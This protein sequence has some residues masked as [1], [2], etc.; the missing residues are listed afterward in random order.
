MPKSSLIMALAKVMIAAAWAD[1]Q[2]SNDE[3]NSLKDLLFHLPGM[4][5]QDWAQLEIY[6]ASPVDAEERTRL[7]QEL[8]DAL[9][10]S[11]DKALA[12]S[13]LDDIVQADGA[14][15]EQERQVLKEIRAA[16]DEVNVNILSQ[17]GRLL[18][19]PVR[20]RTH[21]SEDAPNREDRLDD[22]MKNRIYYSLSRRLEVDAD[23]L[24]LPE[25][26]LRKL[27][28]AG[29]LMARIAYV[30]RDVT[31]GE[32]EAMVDA[33]AKGWDVE[34]NEA[35][36]VAEVAVSET[37]KDLDYYRLTRQFYEVTSAQERKNFLDVLFAVATGDGKVSHEEMEEI[38]TISKVFKLGHSDF[39]DAKLKVPR[40]MRAY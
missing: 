28:L 15:T 14:V 12:L 37:G 21:A 39:I 27:S 30:N 22:F 16:L 2:I 31:D 33:L 35:A 10:T 18:S 20:R 23:D 6:I 17:M 32:F 29:G 26:L 38:R 7:V 19:G 36:L 1:G 40:D 4:T 13:A 3:I 9:L 34:P 11:S 25:P 8:Q 24:E 5:A